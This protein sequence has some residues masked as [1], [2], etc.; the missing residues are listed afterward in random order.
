LPPAEAKLILD[1]PVC[2]IKGKNKNSDFI[3]LKIRNL[4]VYFIRFISNTEA[5]ISTFIKIADKQKQSPKHFLHLILNNSNDALI[6]FQE[7]MYK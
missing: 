7:E 4:N 5:T 2:C 3:Q 6:L 1:E